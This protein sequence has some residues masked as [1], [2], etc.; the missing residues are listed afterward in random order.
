[1][2][3]HVIDLG[4]Q[5]VPR[6]TSMVGTRWKWPL[7]I[8]KLAKVKGKMREMPLL[9]PP[10]IGE[11]TYG[12]FWATLFDHFYFLSEQCFLTMKNRN[13][14]WSAFAADA[15]CWKFGRG[16]ADIW[17]QFSI[18]EGVHLMTMRGRIEDTPTFHFMTAVP[19]AMGGRTVRAVLKEVKVAPNGVE[20]NLIIQLG[21]HSELEFYDT[22]YFKNHSYYHCG[23]EY[24]FCLAGFALEAAYLVGIDRGGGAE[25]VLWFFDKQNPD[26]AYED[27][28]DEFIDFDAG[29]VS[30]YLVK[31]DETASDFY[32]F[33]TRRATLLASPELAGM[34]MFELL[35]DVGDERPFYLPVFVDQRQLNNRWKNNRPISGK[36]WLQG[37]MVLYDQNFKFPVLDNFRYE[38]ASPTYAADKG[39]LLQNNT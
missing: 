22:H 31:L 34:P 3:D 37:Y 12:K 28:E 25:N 33:Q 29:R 10:E 9:L 39:C 4:S 2:K 35:M 23:G 26:F 6:R 21:D 16:R 27:F 32:A 38:R 19:V 13:F 7:R 17:T 5:N 14:S 8:R 36:L 30:S 18:G 11:T 15:Q 24:V 20:A 1:M